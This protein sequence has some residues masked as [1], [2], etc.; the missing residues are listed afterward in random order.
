MIVIRL[1]SFLRLFWLAL[2]FM[3]LVWHFYGCKQLAS[4]A[5]VEQW[6]AWTLEGL[7]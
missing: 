7:E 2:M 5:G 6:V 3:P 4:Q 1:R